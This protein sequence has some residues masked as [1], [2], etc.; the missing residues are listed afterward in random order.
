LKTEVKKVMGMYDVLPTLGNMFNFSSKYALG[1]DIFNVDDNVV[2][3]ANGNWLTEKV[4]YNSQKEEYLPLINEVISANYIETNTL[5]AEK[6]LSISNDF[7]TCDYIKSE[8]KK[9][10]VK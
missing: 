4:Y 5:K 2:V 7:I 10:G 9:V 1:N 6:L 3:F 8:N